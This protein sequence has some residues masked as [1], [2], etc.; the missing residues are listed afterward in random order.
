MRIT[1]V[2]INI[3]FVAPVL[4]AASETAAKASCIEPDN[5]LLHTLADMRSPVGSL[6]RRYYTA[7]PATMSWLDTIAVSQVRATFDYSVQSTPFMVQEG[8]G[9]DLYRLEA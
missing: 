1:K 9:H 5:T 3:L 6:Q 7:G 8:K 2:V 4:V